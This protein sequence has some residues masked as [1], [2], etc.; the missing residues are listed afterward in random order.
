M[1]FNGPDGERRIPAGEIVVNE[2][3]GATKTCVLRFPAGDCCEVANGRDLEALLEELGRGELS[4]SGRVRSRRRVGVAALAAVLLVVLLSP[5]GREWGFFI[6]MG[7]KWSTP[8]GWGF[9]SRRRMR[10]R[11]R[12]IG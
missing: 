7:G 2:P 9:S 6:I 12:F 1:R 10:C 11:A 8:K 5:A 3:L 4:P